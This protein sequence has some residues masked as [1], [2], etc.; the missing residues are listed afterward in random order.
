MAWIKRNLYFLIGGVVALALM[1]LAGWYLY[2]NYE[3]NNQMLDKLNEQYAILKTLN[4]QNPHPGI[5]PKTDNISLAKEQQQ[6]LREAVQKTRKYFQKIPALPDTPK[7][8]S[9]D[10]S[11]AL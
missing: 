9:L 2:S 7:V 10:Y 11:T 3:L 5:P 1:G 6:Q 8:N 4:E